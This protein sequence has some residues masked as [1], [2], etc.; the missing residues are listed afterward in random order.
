MIQFANNELD[1]PRRKG[2]KQKSQ[3]RYHESRKSSPMKIEEDFEN[4]S[5]NN[6]LPSNRTS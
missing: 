2:L 4:R 1:T 5:H 3:S 6:I